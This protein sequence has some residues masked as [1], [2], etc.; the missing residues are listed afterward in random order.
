MPIPVTDFIA[1]TDPSDT[2]ATHASQYGK[3]GWHEVADSTARDA[4]T[5]E[6]RVAGMAVYTRDTDKLWILNDDLTTWTEFVPGGSQVANNTVVTLLAGE[7][8]SQN[9][10][11]SADSNGKAVLSD[12]TSV[13]SAYG[14]LGVTMTS[15]AL[16]EE[17]Q[18][19][20]DGVMDNPSWSW[21]QNA[22]V[23]LNGLGL[24]TQTAPT[25]GVLL[26]VATAVS[27]TRIIVGIKMPL[28]LV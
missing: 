12:Q 14:A 2:Y 5:T 28:V 3:G 16:D 9:R 25:S 11:V 24:M 20:T 8:L 1:T 19:V 21:T 22:P 4:I 7:S 23:Y 17:V 18:V 13:A 27:A 26:Q 10:V 15:G 6:R